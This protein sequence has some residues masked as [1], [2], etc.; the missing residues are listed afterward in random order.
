MGKGHKAGEGGLFVCLFAI[1]SSHQGLGIKGCDSG[2]GRLFRQ[3][4]D[5]YGSGSS[6][7]KE[8]EG[9]GGAEENNSVTWVLPQILNVESGWMSLTV[10]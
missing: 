8:G 6:F 7:L 4:R 1:I 10:E 9:G 5:G 3:R 2:G